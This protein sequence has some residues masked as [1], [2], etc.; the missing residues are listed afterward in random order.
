MMKLLAPRVGHA[1]RAAVPLLLLLAAGGCGG[2]PE[3]DKKQRGEGQ[4]PPSQGREADGQSKPLYK[5]IPPAAVLV[6]VGEFNLMD[7]G[8]PFQIQV[9]NSGNRD[10]CFDQVQVRG[11]GESGALRF[12]LT[13]YKSAQD[14]TSMTPE[15]QGEPPVLQT[16]FL[17]QVPS[18]KAK[19]LPSMVIQNALWVGDKRRDLSVRL[20]FSRAKVQGMD[21][22]VPPP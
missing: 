9:E 13:I 18:Q 2:D 14:I 4:S 8:V 19:R 7:N 3:S 22:D 20:L 16:E 10:L 17:W 21:C 15:T 6:S 5:E 1:L 11:T 12:G